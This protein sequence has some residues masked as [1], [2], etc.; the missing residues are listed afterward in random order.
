MYVELMDSINLVEN[1]NMKTLL[2]NVFKGSTIVKKFKEHHGAIEIHHNWIGGLLEHTLEVLNYSQ[3]T[4]QLFPSLNKYLLITGS[5]LH[6]IGKLEE[7]EVTSRIKG[8]NLGQL[9]GHLVL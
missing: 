9:T 2:N 4:L 6:D 5:L 7:L 3:L 8:T 1:D